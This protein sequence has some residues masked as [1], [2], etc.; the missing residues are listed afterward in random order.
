[1]NAKRIVFSFI[2]LLFL[3]T[4]IYVFVAGN[5]A[6]PLV[7]IGGLLSMIAF[8][9]SA[10]AA[11]LSGNVRRPAVPVA[12]GK[13]RRQSKMQVLNER[14]LAAFHHGISSEPGRNFGG[15]VPR[16]FGGDGIGGMHG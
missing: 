11:L 3:A 2:A 12:R 13:S 8:L 10:V 15:A 14:S 9:A 4:V 1:M 7:F 16:M 6:N 5:T